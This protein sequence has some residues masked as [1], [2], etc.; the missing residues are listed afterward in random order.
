MAAAEAAAEAA[1]ANAAANAHA[2][3]G[4]PT[5]LPAALPLGLLLSCCAP[6]DL[7]RLS[8]VCRE[9]RALARD[10]GVL[11][12]AVARHFGLARVGGNAR[13]PEFWQAVDAAAGSPIVSLHALRP[14]DSLPSLAL[15]YGCSAADVRRLNGLGSDGA[16]SSYRHVAVPLSAA[17]RQEAGALPGGW[18][19]RRAAVRFLGAARR[20]V[21]LL[22]PTAPTNGDEPDDDLE[23]E[24]GAPDPGAERAP[25]RPVP[26]TAVVPGDAASPGAPAGRRAARADPASQPGSL[27]RQRLCGLVGRAAR[28]DTGSA[29]YYLDEAEG[30]VASALRE[31][32]EDEAW[33]R[34]AD[35]RARAGA[36]RGTLG[37]LRSFIEARGA[38]A[39][40]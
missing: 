27:L 36:A 1:A 20:E 7:P 2:H 16:L 25:R 11:R 26:Q 40:A 39:R 32:R 3:A 29:S 35:A 37:P 12:L 34:G 24:A 38:L 22:L 19:R 13:R 5:P 10:Q 15:R 9:F 21:L 30:D 28:V 8:L 31:A 33:E 6:R 23:E 4:S 17:Q 18:G 14:G